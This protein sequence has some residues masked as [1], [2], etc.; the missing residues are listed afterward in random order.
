MKCQNCGNLILPEDRFCY[1]CG[2]RNPNYEKNNKQ[3]ASLRTGKKGSKKTTAKTKQRKWTPAALI[4]ALVLIGLVFF[5]TRTA[6]DYRTEQLAL[7]KE[8]PLVYTQGGALYVKYKGENALSIEDNFYPSTQNGDLSPYVYMDDKH[9]HLFYLSDF[10][11]NGEATLQ[12]VNLRDNKKENKQVATGVSQLYPFEMQGDTIFYVK[13]SNREAGSFSLYRNSIRDFSKES[14]VDSDILRYRRSA[15]GARLVYEKADRDNLK[16][17]FV[18]EHPDDPGQQAK[19]VDDQVIDLSLGSNDLSTLYYTKR[20]QDASA[21]PG[22]LDVYAHTAEEGS[23]RLVSGMDAATEQADRLALDGLAKR[24][25]FYFVKSEKR[26]VRYEDLVSD[27]FGSADAQMQ[28]P[29]GEDYTKDEKQYDFFG[30]PVV[31]KQ[32]D[33]AAYQADL[34]KYLKK[35]QRDKVRDNLRDKEFTFDVFTL[36]HYNGEERL[37]SGDMQSLLDYEPETDAVLYR[38]TKELTKN[39]IDIKNLTTDAINEVQKLV[40]AEKVSDGQLYLSRNAQDGQTAGTLHAN[41]RKFLLD[42]ESQNLYYIQTDAT[43]KDAKTGT[44][45]KKQLGESEPTKVDTD[46]NDFRLDFDRLVYAKSADG[47]NRIYTIVD[48]RSVEIQNGMALSAFESHNVSNVFYYL[49]GAQD[50][51][52]SQLYRWSPYQRETVAGNVYEYTTLGEGEVVYLANKQNT[53]SGVEYELHGPGMDGSTKVQG[54]Y[55]KSQ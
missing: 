53:G 2:A 7:P 33:E 36:H 50:G 47:Q 52:G 20:T 40:D 34:Q 49:S 16:R 14:M 37:I 45:M 26:K 6:V 5:I 18:M 13:E 27:E 8:E 35:V 25:S 55:L 41:G 24:G 17:L 15:D 43:N 38:K 42:K 48:G 29:R 19:Q 11:Q 9:H 3:L 51:S 4:T 23:K 10:E 44:L 46:V 32:F 39:K 21:V 22:S 30:F 1:H 12:Y 31:Y 54:I 28:Q